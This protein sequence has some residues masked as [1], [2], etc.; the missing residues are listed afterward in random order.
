[1]KRIGWTCK[2]KNTH[3]CSPCGAEIHCLRER[4]VHD[5][6]SK[7]NRNTHCFWSARPWWVYLNMDSIVGLLLIVLHSLDSASLHGVLEEAVTCCLTPTGPPNLVAP[8]CHHGH[9]KDKAALILLWP[10]PF[11]PFVCILSRVG[12][13]SPAPSST[14]ASPET[15]F[16]IASAIFSDERLI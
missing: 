7:F 16:Y 3:L 9:V 2:G 11:P 14:I 4:R 10:L 13:V 6:L 5:N 15:T 8:S 12:Q 1:M